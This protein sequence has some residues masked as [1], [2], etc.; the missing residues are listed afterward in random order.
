VNRVVIFL[1]ILLIV[2]H[3]STEAGAILHKFYDELYLIKI[4]P[5][6]DKSYVFY[7][8]KQGISIIWWVKEC[9]NDF[10]YICTYF[11]VSISAAAY[12]FR[13]FRVAGLF[14]IYHVISHFLLWYNFRTTYEVYWLLNITIIACI[15]AMFIPDRKTGRVVGME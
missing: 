3:V 10:L 13:L 4:N 8:D 2:G 12:S 14:F 7:G 15:V 6:L 1:C 9:C 11:V 5:W